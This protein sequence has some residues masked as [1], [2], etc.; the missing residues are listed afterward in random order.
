[1][2]QIF[3]MIG[4]E[5]S[6]KAGLLGNVKN[7]SVSGDGTCVNSGGSS[8]G[9]KVCICRK[10]VFTTVTASAGSPTPVPALVGTPTMNSGTMV[11][12]SI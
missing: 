2:Q 4:V 1:M 7:L 10:T 8:F 6:A 12:Q 9:I 5:P 11:I 3:A